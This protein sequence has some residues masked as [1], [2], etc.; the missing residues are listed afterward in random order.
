MG[1][2]AIYFSWARHAESSAP[3][4]RIE[5]RF[6][7]LFESR[8]MRWPLY[9]ELSESSVPDQGISGFIDHILL[10]NFSKF[11]EFIEELTSSAPK[12]AERHNEHGATSLSTDFLSD[13]STLIVISFDSKVTQQSASAAE[14]EA[15]SSFL[16]DSDHFV[17]VCPHHCIGSYDDGVH[18]ENI[19]ADLAEFRHHG[20]PTIPPRQQFGGFAAS[21][22][23]GLGVPVDNRFGLRAAVLGDGQPAPIFYA[24]ASDRHGLLRGVPAFN[25]H[26]HLPHL[27]RLGEARAKLEVLAEQPLDAAAP[28]HP[29]FNERRSFDAF[30]QSRQDTFAGTLFVCDATLWSSTAGGMEHLSRF[31]RNA[32]NLAGDAVKARTSFR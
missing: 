15:L 16:A 11:I 25:C 3:L 20:D 26:P 23:A 4:G 14:L 19:D 21:L 28:P 29:H 9:E 6:P 2:V 5:D 32:V 17:F 30:L 12:C 8:R 18:V 24:E 7:T 27:E 10:K 22:L 1:R 13:V 31:W